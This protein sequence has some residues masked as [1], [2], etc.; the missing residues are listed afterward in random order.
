MIR[1][2]ILV[3][4]VA[5][6]LAVVYLTGQA[7]SAR[8]SRTRALDILRERYARGEIDRQEFDDRRRL[9]KP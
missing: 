8:S 7:L 1:I 6:A 9:L 4:F 2:L 5:A 3:L